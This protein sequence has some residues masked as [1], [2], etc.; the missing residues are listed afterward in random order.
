MS[1]Y[2]TTQYCNPQTSSDNNLKSHYMLQFSTLNLAGYISLYCGF[3]LDDF[4]LPGGVGIFPFTIMSR[5][6][7][8]TITFPCSG[9]YSL[10]P[11][12]LN[13]HSMKCTTH[14]YLVLTLKYMWCSISITSYTYMAQWLSTKSMFIFYPLLCRMWTWVD[15]ND[16]R[17]ITRNI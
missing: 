10:S 8:G 7:L 13:D 11:C 5:P 3:H 17:M 1:T 16:K 15:M 12:K 4:Q 14:L 6:G 9:W 2:Q